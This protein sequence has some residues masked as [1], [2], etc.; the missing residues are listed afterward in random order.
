MSI[1]GKRNLTGGCN[2][3]LPEREDLLPNISMV[4]E[5]GVVMPAGPETV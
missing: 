4:G 5:A 2:W 1:C 3:G